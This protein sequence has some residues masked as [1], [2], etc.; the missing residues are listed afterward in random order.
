MEDFGSE[1]DLGGHHWVLVREE[2][3]RVEEPTLVGSLV[4]ARDRHKKVAWVAFAGH[5]R[6]ADD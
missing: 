2:E 6:D 4:G 1:E 5:S 3:F